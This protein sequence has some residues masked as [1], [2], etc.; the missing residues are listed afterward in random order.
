MGI[1]KPHMEQAA[2]PVVLTWPC[3]L[4]LRPVQCAGEA[5]SPGT[6][7]QGQCP[8]HC[9]GEGRSCQA[10]AQPSLLLPSPRCDCGG[11][12]ALVGGPAHS[13]AGSHRPRAPWAAL[14]SWGWFLG[15]R[16]S[17]QWHFLY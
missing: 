8:A 16:P 17:P 7:P 3:G 6:G 12:W 4:G 5:L 10:K 14:V 2:G 1:F 11:L 13:W 9:P 15:V